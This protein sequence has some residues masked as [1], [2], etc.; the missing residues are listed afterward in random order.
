MKPIY[1]AAAALSL[2]VAAP[3][4]AGTSFLG[5]TVDGSFYFPDLSTLFA[6]DGLKVVSPSATFV[7]FTGGDNAFAVVTGDQ[8]TITFDTGAFYSSTTFNGY[9][10][11]DTSAS[12]ITGA[13]LDGS[14]T[15]SPGVTFT[16]D[17]VDI[18]LQGLAVGATDSIIVDVSFG[19]V[20]EPATWGLMLVGFAAMGAALR[21]RRRLLAA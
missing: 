21:S 17:S 3:A 10:I 4:Y 20:P 13:V 18:N 2:I 19:A 11:T 6:D 14:S 8:I 1:A 16:S 12:N 7:T 15:L 9:V 5:D